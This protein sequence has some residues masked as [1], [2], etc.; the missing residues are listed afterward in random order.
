MR[1]KSAKSIYIEELVSDLKFRVDSLADQI[2]EDYRFNRDSDDDAKDRFC[3]NLDTVMRA[4]SL[5]SELE[6]AIN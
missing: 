4:Q 5:I 3:D 1:K 6:K 2:L